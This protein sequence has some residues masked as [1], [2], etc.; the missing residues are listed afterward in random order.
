MSSR[1]SSWMSRAGPF[2]E[3]MSWSDRCSTSW[4]SCSADSA[5]NSNKALTANRPAPKICGWHSDAIAPS[6]TAC[7]PSS[8]RELPEEGR[9]HLHAVLR[10]HCADRL[11]A[12]L[13]SAVELRLGENR[14]RSLEDLARP[15]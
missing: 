2:E 1:V 12:L 4:R 11:D 6:S 10:R 7:S 14:R 15:L 13:E 5:P 8:R 3:R 9:I